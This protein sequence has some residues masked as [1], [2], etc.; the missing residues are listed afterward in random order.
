MFSPSSL[1]LAAIFVFIVILSA[2]K[3]THNIKDRPPIDMSAQYMQ[4]ANHEKVNLLTH[5]EL[6]GKIAIITPEERKSTYVNWQQAEQNIDFTLTNLIGVSLLNL[7]FDGNI[8]TLEADGKTYQDTSTE[9]L[10]YQTTGWILPLDE[11]VQWIKGA[12]QNG[13]MV[14]NNEQGLP[15]LVEPTCAN[16]AGW[17]IKYSQYKKVQGVWL[18]FSIEVN[19][20]ARQT[21]LKFKVSQWQRQ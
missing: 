11:L 18:P 19:N 15:V 1:K 20:Q 3:N 14:S 16:C 7:S 21:R 2:C 8:A 9:R 5:W 6:S 10:V 12:T 13:D 17:I 4:L